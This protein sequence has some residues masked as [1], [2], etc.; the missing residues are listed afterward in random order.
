MKERFSAKKAKNHLR[1]ILK[2]GD[3]M[4]SIPHAQERLQQ[5]NISTVDCEN[6]LR[7]GLV[8]EAELERGAWRYRVCSP[9]MVVVIEFLSEN[10][11]LIITAWRIK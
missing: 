11:V 9:N 8:E 10:T 3:V 5:R 2:S 4:Y 6:V 7:A 1:K